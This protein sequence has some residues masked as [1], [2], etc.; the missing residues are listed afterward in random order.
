MANDPTGRLL[1][2]AFADLDTIETW[3][4][5]FPYL[6]VE[7]QQEA[8]VV[9][10]E[11]GFVCGLC[12]LAPLDAGIALAQTVIGTWWSFAVPDLLDRITAELKRRKLRLLEEERDDG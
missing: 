5:G 10:N 11:N 6:T 3:L 12:D 9:R 1:E 2:M 8:L 7:R 4:R